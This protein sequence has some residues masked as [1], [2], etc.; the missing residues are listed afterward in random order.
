MTSNPR[1]FMPPSIAV[2]YDGDGSHS[3]VL[4]S[5]RGHKHDEVIRDGMTENYALNLLA[6]FTALARDVDVYSPEDLWDA[7]AGLHGERKAREWLGER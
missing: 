7:V 4:V 3:L 6:K 1:L 2:R 5:S